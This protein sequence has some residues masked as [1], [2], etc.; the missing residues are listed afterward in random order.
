MI[1][2][3]C[4]SGIMKFMLLS[5]GA[6]VESIG[7]SVEIAPGVVMPLMNLGGV[8]SK[9]SNFSLWLQLGGRGLDSAYEY[10]AEVQ[11]SVG[12]AV[13]ESG[14]SR[15]DLFITTKVPCCPNFYAY[16]CSKTGD[17]PAPQDLVRAATA[18]DLAQ[19]GMDSVDLLLLHMPCNTLEQT[20]MAYKALEQAKASGHARAIGVS[21]FNASLL[22]EFLPRVSVPPAVNQC[23]FSI[24]GHK[25][26]ETFRGSDLATLQRCQTAGITYSA[27][28]PLG[29]LSGIDIFSNPDVLAVAAA[30]GKTAAQVAL[31]WV[32]Q[33]GIPAVTASESADHDKADLD[34]FGF[35]LSAEEMARLGAVGSRG[36]GIIV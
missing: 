24:G 16:G 29:G 19:L 27:F 34:V 10:G 9:P 36:V 17:D 2:M 33:Q 5:L 20:V 23:G 4:R 8:S 25:D 11:T 14:K 35:E 7:N 6:C 22:D 12:R 28:S 15:S 30:H 31:R 13:R 26:S 21:N 1:H 18:V 32:V 3:L